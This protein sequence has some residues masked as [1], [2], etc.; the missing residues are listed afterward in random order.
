[1]VYGVW[2]MVRSIYI[3]TELP[4][5]YRPPMRQFIS[6]SHWPFH[7]QNMPSDG[8]LGVGMTV[9]GTMI[10][11]CVSIKPSGAAAWPGMP[12]GQHS[13]AQH[14]TAQHH[15][16][17]ER[18]YVGSHTMGPRNTAFGA[19]CPIAAVQ[20]HT[21]GTH[22]ARTH[23]ARTH[24]AKTCVSTQLGLVCERTQPC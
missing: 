24:T 1:M 6:P 12:V 23:K 8:Q 5:L 3:L 2:C 13:T 9:C 20:G 4:G 14:S 16:R 18:Q 21:A 19:F 11:A 15:T 7:S 22:K 17:P 10:G